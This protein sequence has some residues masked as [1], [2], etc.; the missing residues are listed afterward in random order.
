MKKI[1]RLKISIF[2]SFIFFIVMCGAD[3]ALIHFLNKRPKTLWPFYHWA[4]GFEKIPKYAVRSYFEVISCEGLSLQEPVPLKEFVTQNKL[5]WR[6]NSYYKYAGRMV[7]ALHRMNQTNYQLNKKTLEA[8]ILSK[9][10]C[11]RM[12]YNLYHF[13]KNLMTKKTRKYFIKQLE[14]VKGK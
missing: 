9:L 4:L 11:D 6:H 12:E 14:Y 10:P 2:I 7:R 5:H 13:S 3:Y 8:N 1:H